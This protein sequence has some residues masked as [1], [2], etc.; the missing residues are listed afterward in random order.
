MGNRG[1]FHLAIFLVV[2]VMAHPLSLVSAALTLK[3]SFNVSQTYTDNLFY[4]DKNKVDDFGTFSGPNLELKYANP[5]IV[6]G[7]T[8]FGRFVA[9]VNDPGQNR[10]IQNAN[11][12]LGLPFLTKK[13]KNLTVTIDEGMDFTPQLDAFSLSGAKDAFTTAP[14]QSGGPGGGT[15]VSGS[16]QG[17]GGTQGVFTSRASSFLNRAGITLGYAWS[18][19]LTPTLTYSNQ[20]RHFFSSQFQDSLVHTGFFSLPYEMTNATITP[21]YFYRE[22]EFIGNSTG[23]TSAD[24]IMS[25]NIQLQIGYDFTPSLAGS[26]RGGV[27]FTK[28]KNA[29]EFDGGTMTN[30]SN[31]WQTNPIGGATLTKTY[32]NGSISLDGYSTIGSGAGLAA[33]AVRSR[34]ITGRIQHALSFKMNAFASFGYAQNNSIS[35]GNALNTNTYRIQSGVGYAFLPWLF[36]NLIYSHIDQSSKGSAAGNVQVNEVFLGLTTIADPWVL[37]R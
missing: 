19:R 27:A 4:D 10:Y 31:K 1:V 16:S 14:V 12:I 32:R 35:D 26:I 8:Y 15:Q 20:Y 6:I 5:D 17:F 9:Y 36:G 33:Q 22:A 7:G 23:N 2:W 25:H 3:S 11:I 37:I 30:L 34:I 21:L 29:E 24:K 18:P 28:S 13:Y